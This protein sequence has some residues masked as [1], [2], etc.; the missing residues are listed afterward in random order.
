[1]YPYSKFLRWGKDVNK[2]Q[3][4]KTSGTAK[5]SRSTHLVYIQI[6]KSLKFQPLLHKIEWPHTF[7]INRWTECALRHILSSFL[8]FPLS[9]RDFSKKTES[10]SMYPFC[11]EKYCYLSFLPP[12]RDC[13]VRLKVIEGIMSTDF[14]RLVQVQCY[15][16]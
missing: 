7:L 8:L 13:E 15:V 9:C 6:A 1:M 12:M 5:P 16:G 4:K 10:K 11:L 14:A 2:D 3:N